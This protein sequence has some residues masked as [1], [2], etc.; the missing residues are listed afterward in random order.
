MAAQKPNH[1]LYS[2]LRTL[3]YV[4]DRALDGFDHHRRT[5]GR[6]ALSASLLVMGTLMV[7]GLYTTIASA[8]T[9]T[10]DAESVSFKLYK[11]TRFAECVAT[12]A[13]SVNC[14][15]VMTDLGGLKIEDQQRWLNKLTYSRGLDALEYDWCSLASCLGGYKIVPS[16]PLQSAYGYSGLIVWIQIL[17]CITTGLWATRCFFPRGRCDGRGCKGFGI[18]DYLSGLFDVAMWGFWWYSFI[19]MAINPKGHTPVS[20]F[21]W[22]STWRF[23]VQLNFH[24]YAC[25]IDTKSGRGKLFIRIIITLALIQFALTCYAMQI[26]WG[27]IIRK[28]NGSDLKY[29]C[30]ESEIAE[31]P[32]TSLCTPQKLCSMD[33]LFSNAE[34]VTGRD[35]I[36]N[37]TPP[38]FIAFGGLT[39]SI[40]M[41]V[42]MSLVI[43]SIFGSGP[44]LLDF[45]STRAQ[46]KLKYFAAFVAPYGFLLGIMLWYSVSV[47]EDF[48]SPPYKA[49][50]EGPVAYDVQC[51]AVHILVSPWKYYLDVDDSN[52]VLRIVR[53]WF[54]T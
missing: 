43:S 14:T 51:Q 20:I 34:W 16:K 37:P 23:A 10:T 48:F 15:F 1:I 4:S 21:A 11:N 18:F 52:R 33:W 54:N 45:D 8:T 44:R 12:P 50:H 6:L 28:P 31:A 27:D 25:R 40:A 19:V 53:A 47:L 41:F 24:P 17:M 30:L 38:Q 7:L 36:Y 9:D 29:R 49:N 42:F 3:D 39:I 46:G 22:F 32:G 13:E 26:K 35:A 2:P 5:I